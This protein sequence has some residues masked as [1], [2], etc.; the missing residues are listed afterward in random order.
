MYDRIYK[1]DKQLILKTDNKVLF[2]YSLESLSS[3]WYEFK[4]VSVDLHH[5]ERNIPNVMT[6]WEQ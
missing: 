2:S 1:K 4:R 6:D 3:Y 5:D